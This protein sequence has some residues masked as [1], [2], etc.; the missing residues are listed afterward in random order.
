[1]YKSFVEIKMLEIYCKYLFFQMTDKT[2]IWSLV[3][4]FYHSENKWKELGQIFLYCSVSRTLREGFKFWI[5]CGLWKFP[6]KKKKWRT[7]S[8]LKRY[9]SE[10][11]ITNYLGKCNSWI[12]KNREDFYGR[13]ESIW[14]KGNC[15][16]TN[17][18][19]LWHS[20]LNQL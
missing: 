5:L 19:F 8:N 10:K 6:K 13:T 16:T 20:L 3:L 11:K 4:Q 18:S 15:A 14:G 2:K 7:T 17:F 12:K 1:M 9:E